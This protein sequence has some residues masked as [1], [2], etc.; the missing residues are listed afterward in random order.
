M[1]R[2][3]T[4]AF[5][6]TLLPALASAAC[7]EGHERQAMSCADGMVFDAETNTCKVVSG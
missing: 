4:T 1:I 7:W 6:L 5:A 3:L 2:T